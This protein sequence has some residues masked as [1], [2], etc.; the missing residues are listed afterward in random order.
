MKFRTDFVTNSS[1]S[2]FTTVLSVE[3]TDGREVGQW[4]IDD[5]HCDVT[6]LDQIPR[7]GS[8]DELINFLKENLEFNTENYEQMLNC[9][10]IRTQEDIQ[11]SFP[12][13]SERYYE[14]LRE[15]FGDMS[16]IAKITMISGANAW[17]D[18]VYE[19]LEYFSTTMSSLKEKYPGKTDFSTW[20]GIYDYQY[21]ECN[22]T[23][24]LDLKSGEIQFTGTM[25]EGGGE[26]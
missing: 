17:G 21:D 25:P 11:D 12:E 23:G 10:E 3:G 26:S 14:E 22:I 20:Q 16:E 9:G 13:K 19:P 6:R 7:N 4:F 5:V 8:I 1:S 18:E 2:S 24:E 15:N